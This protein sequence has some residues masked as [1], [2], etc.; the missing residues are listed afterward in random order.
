MTHTTPQI[1]AQDLRIG[2]YALA[3]GTD[4]VKCIGVNKRLFYF[5][6]SEGKED[7]YSLAAI[8][9]IPLTPELLE[10]CGCVWIS[11][12][13]WLAIGVP[14]WYLIRRYDGIWILE[15]E[16]FEVR[17]IRYLH[18][19]QNIYHSLNGGELTINLI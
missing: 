11:D 2:N 17:E 15:L 5:E 12:N 19:Y 14:Y 16:G 4:I 9:P 7:S 1:E 13:R 8:T 3:Y 18:E 10:K 6:D